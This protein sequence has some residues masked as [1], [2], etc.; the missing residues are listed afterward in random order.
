MPDLVGQITGLV[1]E[2]CASEQNIFGYSIWT[3]HIQKVAAHGRTLALKMGA[4]AEIVEIAALLHD[5][6]A[7]K[8][9]S[10]A[11]DHHIHGQAEAERILRRLAYPADRIEAVKHCIASHRASVPAARQTPEAVCLANADAMT[12]LEQVPAL[13]YL[14]FNHRGM[15]IDEGTAWVRQK[16]ERT[17]SK[18]DK[19][20]QESM[21]TT[22]I[23]ATRVLNRALG[24]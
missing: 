11:Q 20:V 18:M 21:R 17:W 24:V 15:D 19:P 4:D 22:Y 2:A 10:L 23:E 12:H 6:A 13:L 3:H 1:E 16:L 5:Y 8:D 9:R 7:I 14:A